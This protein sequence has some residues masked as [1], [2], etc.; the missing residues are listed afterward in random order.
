MPT[1]DEILAS[2]T[3]AGL[4][5]VSQGGGNRQVTVVRFAERF[6]DLDNAPHTSIVVLSRA[7]LSTAAISTGW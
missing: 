2:S 5:R 7:A 3:L 1:V 4:R 6:A